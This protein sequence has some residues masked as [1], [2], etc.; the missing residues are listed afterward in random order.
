MVSLM[1]TLNKYEAMGLK[2]YHVIILYLLNLK[3]VSLKLCWIGVTKST[4]HGK[5]F[6]II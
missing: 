6:I 5:V 4:A 3:L 1:I 2:F